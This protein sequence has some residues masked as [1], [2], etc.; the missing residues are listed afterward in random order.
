MKLPGTRCRPAA[1]LILVRFYRLSHSVQVGRRFHRIY[2]GISLPL[3]NKLWFAV[4]EVNIDDFET[5]ESRRIIPCVCFSIEPE[6]ISKGS[7]AFDPKLTFTFRI[8]TSKSPGCNFLP[9]GLWFP[10]LLA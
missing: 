4:D 8:K 10:A 9:S 7:S 3:L 2:C 1:H 5:R 6:F